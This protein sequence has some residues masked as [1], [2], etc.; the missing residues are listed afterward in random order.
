MFKTSEVTSY[1][2]ASDN[3]LNNR[4]F[5]A[6][7]KAAEM[8]HGNVLEVGCGTGKGLTVF[9]ER[10][11]HYTAID[12][13]TKL[14]NH[15]SKLYPR[16]TFIDCFIPPLKGVPSNAFD[17]VVSLQVIEHIEDDHGFLQEIVRVLKPGGKAILTT[18]N[19]HYTLSR[20]PWHVREYTPEQFEKLLEKYFPGQ[21]TLQGVKG[22]PAVMAYHEQNRRSVQRIMRWDIFDL[23]HKLPRK[24]L[25]IPYDILNR[26][27]RNRLMRQDNELVSS[28]GLEDFSL[29]SNPALCLDLFAVVTKV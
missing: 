14:L 24:L 18:P 22:S 9:A 15:L 2:I 4:L 27:N 12:K 17:V 3:V 23:Q 26:I 11:E 28:I 8:V 29:E 1:E 13:N 20:N 10:C 25:Q 6:Y 16:F 7:K 5:F 21:V 19:I